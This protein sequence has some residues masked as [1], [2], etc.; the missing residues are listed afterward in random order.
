MRLSAK[1]RDISLIDCTERITQAKRAERNQAVK[2]RV[3]TEVKKVEAA[4]A[5]GN[6]EEAAK[7]LADATSQIE[8]AATKGVL[9]KNTASRKV[10][11]LAKIVNSM[12]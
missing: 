11:R 9:K 3:K 2:S 10:S 7:V 1:T 6:K 8:K 5:A 12:E 4:A